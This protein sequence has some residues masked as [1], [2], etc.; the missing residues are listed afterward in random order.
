MFGVHEISPLV[1]RRIALASA[2]VVVGIL[3]LALRLWDLQ[4]IRGEQ[5]AA[6]SENNRI[7]LRRV[8]A[9]RGRVVDRNGKVLIDSQASFDA[10]LVPEDARDLSSTVEMIAQFLHQSAGETQAM[11]ARA[12]GR[13]PFQ[14]VLVK[15]NLDF[16]EVAA[17]ETHQLEL[18]GVSLRIMQ[19]HQFTAAQD[20][21]SELADRPAR[22]Q[23]ITVNRFPMAIH[24]EDG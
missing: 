3:L 20:F 12:A 21:A 22:H 10:V 23:D 5:M 17:L 16:D 7:R 13:P 2:L 1:R 4:V 24:V 19:D 6:L 15:R 18:P 8:P 11:L 14:E 9:T